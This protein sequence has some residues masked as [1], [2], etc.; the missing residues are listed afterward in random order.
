MMMVARASA[1][2]PA[3][4][5]DPANFLH[6]VDID[7]DR[8]FFL[9]TDSQL[10][11]DASFLDGRTSIATTAPMPTPLSDAIAKTRPATAIDRFLFNCSFCG[12]TLL[13]RL[14]DIPGRSLVLKEPRCLT[15]IAA[16]KTFEARDGK[17]MEKLRPS[18]NFARAALRRRFTA[19]E[20]VSVKVANQGNALL[21]TLAE[22]AANIR[23]IFITISRAS[24]L[25]AIFRG[26]VERMH[27][28]ASIA[29]HMATDEPDGDALLREAVGVGADPLRKAANLAILARFLQVGAFQRAARA[30]GWNDAHVIDY[31]D[32][33]TQPL[34][35]AAKAARALDLDV[36]DNDIEQNVERFA[37]RYAK[38]P[39][40][41]FSNDRQL[42]ADRR[43]QSEH[44][45]VFEDALAWAETALGP[46]RTVVP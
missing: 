20:A 45:Q 22:D 17:P 8:A 21:D 13:A 12:S 33:T 9:H 31:D 1:F 19:N 2:D 40:V 41:Q 5:E 32:I 46:Q 16:W 36:N 14:L 18:L 29:W 24:F 38:Q 27:H 6:S 34:K 44:R 10:L 26:G 11:R 3:L 37:G 42:V 39:D 4:L 25:R 28:A 30:G 43:V 23:P 15:D 7:G 35:A